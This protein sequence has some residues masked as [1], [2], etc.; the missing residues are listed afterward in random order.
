M[1]R[2]TQLVLDTLTGRER[3]TTA[4]D[5][6]DE[7]RRGAR[8]VGITT[9]YRALNALLEAGVVHEFRIGDQSG[10][11]VCPPEP[12]EH[13]IC[14]VCGRVQPHDLDGGHWDTVAATAGFMV[15]DQRVE[16]YGVCDRCRR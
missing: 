8:R 16:L 11:R 12:H 13:L 9:V 7:L 5:L 15:A 1:T 4:Y 10:Y 14:R 3:P 2:N 6:Y